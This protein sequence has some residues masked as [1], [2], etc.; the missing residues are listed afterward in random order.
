MVF[1]RTRLLLEALGKK[2]EYRLRSC[3]P[4]LLLRRRRG[5]DRGKPEGGGMAAISSLLGLLT[6]L[7]LCEAT[8]RFALLLKEEGEHFHS[9]GVDSGGKRNLPIGYAAEAGRAHPPSRWHLPFLK[10]GRYRS[11]NPSVSDGRANGLS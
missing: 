9:P 8:A 2:Q 1:F 11:H 5:M 3:A 6:A 7:F 4:L 10:K